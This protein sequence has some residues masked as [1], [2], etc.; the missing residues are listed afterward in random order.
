MQICS[1]HA[2]DADALARIRREAILA[3]AGAILSV[4]QVAHWANS[5]A[6]DRCA[7]AIRDHAVWIA[8]DGVPIGWVEV[9]G[10]H[11]AAL[12]VAPA[13]ARRGVGSA[14]LAHAETAIRN[15]GYVAARL[16]ASPN[17]LGFYLRRGYIG[18]GVPDATGAY[19]LRKPL[20]AVGRT[21]A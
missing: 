1:A 21:T 17:A 10:D 6:A 14:L 18:D 12:Y 3:L 20:A 4:E 5:A 7:R 19:P 2:Y 8:I 9:D 13:W 11:I 16:A 15:A